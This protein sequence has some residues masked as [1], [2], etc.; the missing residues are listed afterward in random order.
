MCI[1]RDKIRSVNLRGRLHLD[2]IGKCVPKRRLFGHIQR[3]NKCF[4]ICIC[5][6]GEVVGLV[7]RRGDKHGFWRSGGGDK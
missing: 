4:W 6:I 5:G 7:V 2:S 1:L 3:M